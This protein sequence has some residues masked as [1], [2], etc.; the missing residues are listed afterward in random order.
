MQK[1]Q[2]IQIGSEFTWLTVIRQHHRRSWICLCKCGK[3]VVV[4]ESELN[5]GH[6]KSCGCLHSEVLKTAGYKKRTHGGSVG[7]TQTGKV[8]SEYGVW[9]EMRSRCRRATNLRYKDYGGRGIGVCDRWSNSFEN[10]LLDMGR[11]P[12]PELTIERRNNNGDYTPENCYWGTRKEQGRN[13]RNNAVI[14]IGGESLCISEWSER[15]G[16][17]AGTLQRRYKAG[18]PPDKFLLPPVIGQKVVTTISSN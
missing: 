2:Q 15:S 3:E 4:Y 7:Q 11:K 6:N 13:K 17:K 16:I 12:S 9:R 14:T 8:S 5:N 1:A 10:F 18:W